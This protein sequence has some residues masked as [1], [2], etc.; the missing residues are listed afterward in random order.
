MSDD[1]SALNG[2]EELMRAT[3]SVEHLDSVSTQAEVLAA[4]QG[5][6]GVKSADTMGGK[7]HVIYDP[8]IITE[9]ELEHLIERGGL[10]PTGGEAE[11]D[12]PF[13]DM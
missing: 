12:S 10:H 13:S 11:R 6:E 4:V 8:V 3:I 9:H 2:A 7:L 1:A 5:A